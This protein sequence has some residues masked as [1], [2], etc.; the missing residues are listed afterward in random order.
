MID[1]AGAAIADW[2]SS[3]KTDEPADTE[4]RTFHAAFDSV[5]WSEVTDTLDPGARRSRR[6]DFGWTGGSSAGLCGWISAIWL[7]VNSNFC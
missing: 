5:P 3:T 4:L 1:G 2:R 7:P 6:S